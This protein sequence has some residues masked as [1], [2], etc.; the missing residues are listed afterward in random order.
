M[1]IYVLLRVSSYI[2]YED[3][4][5]LLP[6]I[7]IF[8]NET[9]HKA[10]NGKCVVKIMLT[11]CSFSSCFVAQWNLVDFTCMSMILFLLNIPF[12]INSQ[13]KSSIAMAY[14]YIT[15]YSFKKKKNSEITFIRSLYKWNVNLYAMIKYSKVLESSQ[16][17]SSVL[18]SR[19]YLDGSR[20]S[21]VVLM[22][23]FDISS[24]SG[25][26]FARLVSCGVS[27]LMYCTCV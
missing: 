12:P 8:G 22:P 23:I 16:S 2:R 4:L 10:P 7:Y 15:W 9:P 24:L 26:V 19:R 20:K 11:N 27:S 18:E 3:F 6:A 5:P 21:L 25:A 17:S 13:I 1:S 14:G